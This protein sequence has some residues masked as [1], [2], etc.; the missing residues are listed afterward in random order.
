MRHHK[1]EG[2]KIIGGTA[3]NSVPC[4]EW[5]PRDFFSVQ[6][7]EARGFSLSFTHI[8]TQRNVD[9]DGCAWREAD[10]KVSDRLGEANDRSVFRKRNHN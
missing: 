7:V 2:E 4:A 1:A 10:C 9:P 8:R 3:S 5:R 6:N